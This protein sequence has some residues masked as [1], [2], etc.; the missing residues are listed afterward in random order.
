MDPILFIIICIAMFLWYKH[1]EQETTCAQVD[2]LLNYKKEIDV[3]LN[4]LHSEI[5]QLAKIQET[6]VSQQQILPSQSQSVSDMLN[7]MFNPSISQ[8][9]SYIPQESQH[10]NPPLHQLNSEENQESVTQVSEN[11]QEGLTEVPENH[12]E[13]LTQVPETHQESL[14]EVPE[15]HQKRLDKDDF[16]TEEIKEVKEIK[17]IKFNELSAL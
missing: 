5:Q 9:H 3:S 14:T 11:H 12:Q 1:T 7:N 15:N 2:L 4:V 16:N 13:S 8:V 17:Y 10:W 6:F